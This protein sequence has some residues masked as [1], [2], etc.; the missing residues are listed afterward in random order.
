MASL[1]RKKMM[2]KNS[3]SNKTGKREKAA[4]NLHNQIRL[5]RLKKKIHSL[6][7]MRT[8]TKKM[9]MM[10]MMI[11]ITAL[12]ADLKRK[13]V[14]QKSNSDTLVQAIAHRNRINLKIMKHLKSFLCDF[15]Y[16]LTFYILNA[17]DF[18]T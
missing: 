13:E 12:T 2:K 3:N 8:K 9:K 18:I 15:E 6:M 5:Q 4:L 14:N 17:S 1:S 16:V 11:S 7:M 10:T